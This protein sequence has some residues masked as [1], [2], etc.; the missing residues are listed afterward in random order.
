V[1]EEAHPGY[2]HFAVP[3]ARVIGRADV[4]NSL[5]DA[6]SAGSLYDW[7]AAFPERRELTGRIPAYALPLPGAGY[8]VVVRHNHHGGLL[9]NIRGDRFFRPRAAYE[10]AAAWRLTHAGIPTPEVIACALYRV[11]WLEKRSDLM[12]REL[13]AGRDLGAIIAAGSPSPAQMD[14]VSTLVRMLGEG[15]VWHPDLNARN[16]YVTDGADIRAYVLDLDRVKFGAAPYFASRA[17]AARLTRSVRKIAGGRDTRAI[18]TAIG[19]AP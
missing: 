11:N 5:R 7:A 15:G 16:I 1:S 12:T 6:M 3:G 9:A 18:L 2:A 4:V 19:V 10:L 14:A 17:N 8:N 13:P